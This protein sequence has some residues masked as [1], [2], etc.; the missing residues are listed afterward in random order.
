[1]IG[2]NFAPKLRVDLSPKCNNNPNSSDYSISL[3]GF[4][5]AAANHKD[6]STHYP[7]IYQ[8]LRLRIRLRWGRDFNRLAAANPEL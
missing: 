3:A 4:P 1:M 6:G 7:W 8:R 5:P 2:D